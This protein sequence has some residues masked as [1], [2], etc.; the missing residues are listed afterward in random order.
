MTQSP[1]DHYFTAQP[2]SAGELRTVPVHL[3]GRDVDVVTA[4][5]IFSPDGIDKGTRVL[6]A[7]AP[8]S[9]SG[10]TFLDLGCGWGPLALTLAMASPQAT[11]AA[12]ANM[13]IICF[14]SICF[15]TRHSRPRL[16]ANPFDERTGH[17]HAA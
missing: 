9:P 2:A 11:V 14:V 5:G 4:G 8:A 1:H 6:L 15:I 13:L 10:G 7:E 17:G 16:A 3:A 12:T